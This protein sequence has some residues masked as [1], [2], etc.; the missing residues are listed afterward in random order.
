MIKT[1]Y[2]KP[3]YIS[4]P[5]PPPLERIDGYGKRVEDQRFERLKVPS[6]LEALEGRYYAR[7]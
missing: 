5:T 7:P 2:L 6:R 4:L 3:I 1:P